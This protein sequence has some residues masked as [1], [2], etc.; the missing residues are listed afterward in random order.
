MHNL[1]LILNAYSQLLCLSCCKKLAHGN[2]AEAF[3]LR[4]SSRGRLTS[5]TQEDAVQSMV[6]GSILLILGLLRRNSE[7]A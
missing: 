1:L 5:R 3:E 7:G 2:A 4:S 6:F